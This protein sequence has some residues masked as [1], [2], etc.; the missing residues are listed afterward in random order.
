MADAPGGP[1]PGD[2][3]REGSSAHE[4]IKNAMVHAVE[5]AA[6]IA[7]GAAT[8]VASVAKTAGKGAVTAAESAADAASGAATGVAN[9]MKTAGKGAAT[10]AAGVAD[11]ATAATK[12]VAAPVMGAMSPVLSPVTDMYADF[13]NPVVVPQGGGFGEEPEPGKEAVI[14]RLEIATRPQV[15]AMRIINLIVAIVSLIIMVRDF[16]LK[17]VD[18][19]SRKHHSFYESRLFLR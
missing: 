10:A 2:L 17:N 12:A 19:F 5:S 11:G 16:L 7:T 14:L 13:M 8:G 6:D 9:V 4:K 3:S 15:K 18:E 1:P